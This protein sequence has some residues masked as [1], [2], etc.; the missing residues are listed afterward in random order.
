MNAERLKELATLNA[1]GALDGP[2]LQEFQS[3]VASADSATQ[4]EL[5]RWNDLAV[6]AAIAQTKPCKVPGHLKSRVLNQIKKPAAASLPSFYS[7]LRN[8]GEWKTLPVPGV[9]VKDL[10]ENSRHGLS[11]KI[12]E[13]AAGAHFPS[14]HHTSAEECFVLSGDFH[15]EG[16]VL[17][18]GDF[19][20]AEAETDH[21]ESFTEGGCQLLVVVATQDYH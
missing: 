20:H 11:V 21:G 5:G 17:Q 4:A 10:A 2:D 15:V 12:Y 1:A 13:L 19:H 3:L 14:H 8:E 7:I 16:R 6:A 9:R 18:G